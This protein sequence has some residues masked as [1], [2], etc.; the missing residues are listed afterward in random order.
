MSAAG[1]GA[2]TWRMLVGAKLAAGLLGV[3]WLGLIT[4]RL[5]GEPLGVYF[6]LLAAFE[7]LL[8]VSSLGVAT[9]CDRFIAT[10]WVH[11]PRGLV[12]RRLLQVLAWRGVSLTLAAGALAA[13]LPALAAAMRWPPALLPTAATFAAFMLAEGMF[14]FLDVTLTSV[15]HQASSQLLV[16]LRNMARLAGAALLGGTAINLAGLLRIEACVTALAALLA[17]GRLAALAAGLPER[18]DAQALP[19]RGRAAY[20]MQGYAALVLERVASIDVIKLIVSRMAGPGALAAFGLAWAVIDLAA[21]YMPLVLFHGHVRALLTLRFERGARLAE[22][23]A[24]ARLLLRLNTVFLAAAAAWLMLFGES[25]LRGLGTRQD[26]TAVTAYLVALAPLP[27]VQSLRV[28]FGMLAHVERDGLAL[29]RASAAT[30]AAP[31]LAWVLAPAIG[32]AGAV[33]ACWL[34]ELLPCLVLWHRRGP[35]WR[36]L[37]GEPHFWCAV[38]GALG[39]STGLALGLTS[40]LHGLGVALAAALLFPLMYVALIVAMRAFS[41]A[42]FSAMQTTLRA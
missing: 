22:I 38:A 12:Q 10:D 24:D 15:L 36:T 19:S 13:A 34:M 1:G 2:G 31:V 3:A 27:F 23:L 11:A 14:R 18:R 32:A 39:L 30:L 42:E 17:L 5:P 35:T 37:I 8:H 21:R 25:A 28:S 40:M 29:L 26:L 6:G 20:A 4:A 33:A 7:I 9:Y 16:M 41:E